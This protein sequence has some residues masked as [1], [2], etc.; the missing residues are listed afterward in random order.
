[1]KVDWSPEQTAEFNRRRRSRNVALGLFL[2]ALVLLFFGI[3]VV[4][5]VK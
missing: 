5:M 2:G 3:T 1:M 4:R